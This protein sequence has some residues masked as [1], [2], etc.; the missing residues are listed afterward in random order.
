MSKEKIWLHLCGAAIKRARPIP[1][2][3]SQQDSLRIQTRND[4]DGKEYVPARV[5]GCYWWPQSSTKECQRPQKR[6][7]CRIQSISWK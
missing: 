7:P 3:T 5:G 1:P 4:A 6:T 2:I